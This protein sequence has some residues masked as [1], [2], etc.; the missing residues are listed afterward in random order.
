[1][2]AFPHLAFV[3]FCEFASLQRVTLKEDLIPLVCAELSQPR[4]TSVRDQ[5]AV[6]KGY[7]QL[8]AACHTSTEDKNAAAKRVRWGEISEQDA[9]GAGHACFRSKKVTPVVEGKIHV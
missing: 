1:V 2:F 3:V 5:H 9:T 6:Y 8:C 4:R 7:Q